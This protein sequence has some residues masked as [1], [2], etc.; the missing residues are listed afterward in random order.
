VLSSTSFETL[1]SLVAVFFSVINNGALVS[2]LDESDFTI[3]L[4]NP[5]DSD[6]AGTGVGEIPVTVTEFGSSGRYYATYTNDSGEDWRLEIQHTTYL[7]NGI[8]ANALVYESQYGD[9]NDSSATIDFDVRVGNT[10][11]TGLVTGDFTFELWNPSKADVSGTVS[12]TIVELGSGSYR[13][14]FSAASEEGDWYC[15]IKHATYFPLGVTAVWRFIAAAIPVAPQITATD[16]LNQSDVR[17][18]IVADNPADVS[19]IFYQTVP[20]GILQTWG[21]TVTGSGSETITGLLVKPYVIYVVVERGGSNSDPSNLVFLTIQAAD[22][23]T[24]MRTTLYEWVKG[25]VGNP[26]VVWREP[27]AP[28]PARQYVSIHM[29]PTTVVGHDYHGG[30]DDNGVSTVTG[31]REFVFSIQIHGK[32]SNEDGSASISILERLRSSLEKR[33]IQSSLSA[34]GVAFVAIE[35]RGDLAG[36]GGTQWEARVFMDIRFRTAYQD[37]D[38]VGYIAT[39]TDPVG[40]LE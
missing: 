8:G 25:V 26:T 37:A 35:G 7:P 21:T 34:G 27:N 33:S 24:A 31:D 15:A 1:N 19:T 13:A 18:D 4:W 36:I 22:Q 30:A 32:P 6:V 3:R 10:P 9:S 12:V 5:S 40:T 23:Y 38:D 29:G 28:Q 20:G 17:V 16:L 2:G 14:K 39:V 11:I